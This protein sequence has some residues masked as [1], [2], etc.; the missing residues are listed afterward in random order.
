MQNN[1]NRDLKSAFQEVQSW[2]APVSSLPDHVWDIAI[3]GAGPAGAVCAWKLAKFRQRVLLIDKSQFP[4]HKPCGDLLI[5]DS[6]EVLNRIGASDQIETAAHEVGAIEVVSPN[7]T[8]FSIPEYCLTIRRKVVDA[9]L[10]HH[11]LRSGRADFLTFALGLIRH[12]RHS[13]ANGPVTLETSDGDRAGLRAR[14]VVLATGGVAQLPYSM[15]VVESESPS[16]LAFRGYVRSPLCIENVVI[17]YYRSIL[18]GYGWIIPL[19]KAAD[20]NYVYNVGCGVRRQNGSDHGLKRMLGK[21]LATFPAARDLMKDAEG[22][23]ACQGAPL[24]CGLPETERIRKGNLLAIGEAIG[25][26]YPFTGE[27]IG[28]AMESGLI[29]AECIQEALESG[30]LEHL[31]EYPDRLRAAIRNRYEAYLKAEKWLS[32]PWLNDFVSRRIASSA[33]LR[34]RAR[35]LIRE[36]EAADSLFSLGSLVKSYFV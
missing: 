14:I 23:V 31:G 30:N 6:I 9:L 7:G 5:S 29:A 33:Y 36:T 10:V 21:F 20:G 2:Q 24:R 35:N 28:K 34:D 17:A 8:K 3:V 13:E 11:A 1:D 25:T 16:A 15:G 4:R 19:G 26:T 18:P 27:G 22:P 32:Y 12:V